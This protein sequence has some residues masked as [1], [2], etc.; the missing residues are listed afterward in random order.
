[1]YRALILALFATAVAAQEPST[2][3]EKTSYMIGVQ[4]G[5][6]LVDLKD[7][8]NLEMLMLGLK[9]SMHEEKP[10]LS[11]QEMRKLSMALNR[12]MQEKRLSPEQRKEAAENLATGEAFLKKNATAE[13]WQTTDSGLQYKVLKAGDG[14]K[15]KAS[16][17]VTVHYRG[18]LLDGTEFDSSYKRNSPA[19]FPLTG[20]IKG[21]TEGVQL[22]AIG[23]KFSFAIH[24]DIAYGLMGR[25]GIP[26]NA[27]LLFDIELI[28]IN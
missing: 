2:D 23:S 8:V 14:A 7:E 10:V 25:G 5:S 21:W 26:M 9:T 16:D 17:K 4:I 1:M 18:T 13:G 27:V 6:G 20:V 19:S 15:P 12:K 11:D 3:A 24:P 22:M 28:S